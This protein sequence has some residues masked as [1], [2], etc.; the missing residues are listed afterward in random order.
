[1]CWQI[2]FEFRFG[3]WPSEAKRKRCCTCAGAS[4]HYI[5]IFTILECRVV[6]GAG[7][8]HW[9][10]KLDALQRVPTEE[11]ES[12]FYSLLRSSPLV[13]IIDF[14]DHEHDGLGV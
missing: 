2:P 14:H 8:D 13:I 3:R 11:S 6:Q 5:G 10:P 12:A 9:G 4:I 1:M 7:N